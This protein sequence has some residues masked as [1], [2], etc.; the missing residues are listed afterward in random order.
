[1]TSLPQVSL[2]VERARCQAVPA[3][4][5]FVESVGASVDGDPDAFWTC[6]DAFTTLT[7]S[8]FLPD[9]VAWEL[10]CLRNDPDYVPCPRGGQDFEVLRLGPLVLSIRLQVPERDA[11]SSLLFG[12]CEHHLSANVGPGCVSVARWRQDWDGPPDVFDRT[13]GLVPLPSLLLRPGEHVAFQAQRDVARIVALDGAAVVIGFTRMHATPLRWVY[14]A[15]TLL[16]VRAEAA[17]LD[18]ARLEYAM[19]LLAALAHTDAAPAVAA[20][21][22]HPDHFVRWSAVRRTVELD[23]S[24]GALLVQRALHD[25]HPHIRRAA[26]RSL[27]RYQ[28]SQ[29]SDIRQERNSHGAH[30]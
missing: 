10:D 22:E 29:C 18:A 28:A 6:S 8:T 12:F 21:Y 23:P 3:L 17:D 25:V 9:L 11:T 4:L 19:S 2:A 20:L 30:A 16:P 13:R 5:N 15:G 26:Q 1:M 27:E 7:R 24:R 14:D